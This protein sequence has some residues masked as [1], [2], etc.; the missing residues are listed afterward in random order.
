[1]NNVSSDSGTN[2]AVFTIA[3]INCFHPDNLFKHMVTTHLE[4]D[5]SPSFT[6]ILAEINQTF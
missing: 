2:K 5:L 1:M 6:S 4:F 3:K